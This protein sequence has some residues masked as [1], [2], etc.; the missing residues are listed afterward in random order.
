[1]SLFFRPAAGLLIASL[2][3]S[4]SGCA[5]DPALVNASASNQRTATTDAQNALQVADISL[6][7]GAK[8]DAEKS[9]VIGSGERWLGRL[10]IKA[11]LS[12]VQAYNHFYNGMPPIGWT[13]ITAV[14]SKLSHLSYLR[15]DRVASIQIEPV[16]FSGVMITITVSPRQG[17]TSDAKPPR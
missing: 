13:L 7:S 14:Q 5:S 3:L 6:P 2:I 10:V 1:M 16:S 17:A 9:L 12:T 4:A 15:G 11:D 8:L